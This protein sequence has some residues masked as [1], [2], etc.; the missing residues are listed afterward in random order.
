MQAIDVDDA[1]AEAKGAPDGMLGAAM[2]MEAHE[3][4]HGCRV[5]PPAEPRL[6]CL[7]LVMGLAVDLN[8]KIIPFLLE[9]I[10]KAGTINQMQTML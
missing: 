2:P 9:A 3:A 7:C 4:A 10:R 1:A 6:S 5:R 8:Q